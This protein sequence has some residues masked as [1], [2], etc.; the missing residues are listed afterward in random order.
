MTVF[1]TLANL[2][3]GGTM[4]DMVTTSKTD[5][6]RASIALAVLFGLGWTTDWLSRR[7][8]H[9]ATIFEKEPQV[10][11]FKVDLLKKGSEQE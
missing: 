11:V 10:L 5:L 2:A 3:L 8:S 6:A 4:S 7:H 9:F 1:P